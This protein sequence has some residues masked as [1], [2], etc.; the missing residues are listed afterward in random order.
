MT[1]HANARIRVRGANALMEQS[2]ASVTQEAAQALREALDAS[3]A[4]ARRRCP[5]D[6]GA[7]RASIGVRMY[8]SG[9]RATGMIYASAPHAKAVELGTLHTRA[10][11]F[12]YPAYRENAAQIRA[13]IRRQVMRA[14]KGEGEA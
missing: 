10:Q 1:D 13:A 11:P 4:Q 9:T 14:L 6:S 3:A 5:A 2:D 8:G 12:L 7:L